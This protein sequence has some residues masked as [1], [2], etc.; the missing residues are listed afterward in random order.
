M[1]LV[2]IRQRVETRMR[3]S[4]RPPRLLCLGVCLFAV[5][6]AATR[7]RAQSNWP[8]WRGPTGNGVAAADAEPP[9]QWSSNQNVRW[10]V[11]I[12]GEGSSTPIVWK[13]QI[14]LLAAEPTDRRGE[15][16]IPKD[17]LA[18]TNPPEF[19][20]RFLVLCYDRA[21]GKELWRRVANEVVPHEGRHPTNSY[22][23]SSPVTDGRRLFVSFGSYGL[24]CYDLDGNLLWNRELGRMR[25]RYGWGEATSPTLSGD[26]LIVNWDHE[27]PSFIAALDAKTGKT[28]WKRARD[29]P[30]S[31][32]T[33]YA[34][35]YEGKTQVIVNGTNRVRS[36]DLESGEVLWSCGGQT[37][38]AIPSPFVIDDVAYCLS[39]YRGA[40]AFAIPLSASGDV[41]DSPAI[42]WKHGK[43]TPYVPSAL[44]YQGR[45]YFT[46]GN[47]AI[48]TCLRLADGELI[49]GPERLPT[50]RSIYSSPAA[51]KGRVYL[52]GRDGATL[53]LQAGDAFKV[54]ATNKLDEPIDASPA[55]VDRQ[56]FLR[57]KQ[58][59]YCIEAS[60][61]S[62]D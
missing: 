37:V 24:F 41:T 56:L 57:G 42:R 1:R 17:E 43:D 23:S 8:I 26:R 51:A 58:H 44:A 32:A 40:A 20:Y 55:I 59:L 47:Q 61:S 19:F 52:V 18:K 45:L 25:T 21:T 60:V 62:S 35:E 3:F 6:L 46:R 7:L 2:A 12:P 48:L 14:F 27:G 34:V 28:V 33:P 15:P 53:V 38:N 49:F 36:Y 5:G 31:W 54:L 39:G 11:P 22:A 10:K 29:E 16:E 4:M 13:N 30:T 9:L 50:I